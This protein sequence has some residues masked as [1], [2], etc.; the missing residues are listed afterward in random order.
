MAEFCNT[1]SVKL[2]AGR[3]SNYHAEPLF[4][5]YMMDIYVYSIVY[6]DV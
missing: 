2:L 6:I 1:F 5:I 4:V 3:K